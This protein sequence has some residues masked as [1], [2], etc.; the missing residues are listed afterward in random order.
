MP[1]AKAVE[2]GYL[3]ARC[4]VI[5]SQRL[6]TE[7]LGEL[8][9]SRSMGEFVSALSETPYGAFITDTS[10][11]GVHKGLIE[12]F[13]YQRKR[14]NREL[15]KR[16]LEIFELFFHSKYALLD[17]KQKVVLQDSSV[18]S[19][20]E[21]FRKIDRTYIRSL[22]KSM[23]KL[24]FSEQRQIKKIV[25]SYFDFLNLYNLVKFRLLYKRSVEETLSMM[26][27]S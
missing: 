24:S 23:K 10:R 17:E 8:A 15:Q 12:A 22:E 7:S 26:L 5:R 9:G 14:L 20:E 21:V 1:L 27:P 13:S 2:Y 19:S 6:D 18:G 16:H 3:S 4:H 25:G 11:E